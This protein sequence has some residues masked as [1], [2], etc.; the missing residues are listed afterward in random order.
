[1]LTVKVGLAEFESDLIRTRTGEGR[2]QWGSKNGTFLAD[3]FAVGRP[4][5][6]LIQFQRRRSFR[7][8]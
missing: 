5:G 7:L 4:V 1:M 6:G 3:H 2:A 8:Q